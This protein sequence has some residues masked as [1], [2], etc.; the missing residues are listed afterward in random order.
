MTKN[1]YYI[2]IPAMPLVFLKTMTMIYKNKT[3][4]AR[5]YQKNKLF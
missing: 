2:M 3:I 4:Q 5:K 1:H